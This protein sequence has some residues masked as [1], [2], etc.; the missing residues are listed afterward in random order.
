VQGSD[1]ESLS[2]SA[3]SLGETLGKECSHE[4]G[5]YFL[6]ADGALYEVVR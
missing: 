5:H 6:G 2:E 4:L 3:E 1:S